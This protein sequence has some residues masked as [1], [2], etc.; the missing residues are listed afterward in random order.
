MQVWRV[1][2]G[3]QKM[4]E[5]STYQAILSEGSVHA[6]QEDLLALLQERFAAVPPELEARIRATT[7]LARLQA[8]IRQVL[9][10]KSPAELSL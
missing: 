9:H 2:Y 10:I 6:R 7:D 5:S 1:P 8:A 4:R 3:I